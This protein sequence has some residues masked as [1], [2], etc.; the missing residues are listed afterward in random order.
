MFSADDVSG[1]NCREPSLDTF[2][3]HPGKVLSLFKIKSILWGG[4]RQVY[5]GTP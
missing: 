1:Q 3:G 4:S 5:V 2:F